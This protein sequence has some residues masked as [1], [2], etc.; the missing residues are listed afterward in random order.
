MCWGLEAPRPAHVTLPYAGVVLGGGGGRCP[1]LAG[2][3]NDAGGQRRQVAGSR[4]QG[5]QQG[6]VLPDTGVG[7]PVSLACL[8]AV[9]GWKK[10]HR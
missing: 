10:Q 9:P 3:R 2:V 8:I 1:R 4:S 7:S 5:W 6:S